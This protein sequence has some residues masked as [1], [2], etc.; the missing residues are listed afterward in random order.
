MLVRVTPPPVE[1]QKALCVPEENWVAEKVACNGRLC[2]HDTWRCD[3]LVIFQLHLNNRM[4]Y[5][6]RH[7]A[8]IGKPK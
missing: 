5:C 6:G 7:K 2:V 1:R 8:V 4:R 3:K